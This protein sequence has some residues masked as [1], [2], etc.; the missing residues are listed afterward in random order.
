MI[1]VPFLRVR[2]IPGIM[3]GFNRQYLIYSL[4]LGGIE[5]MIPFYR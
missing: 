5:R 4:Q 3:L 2:Y 1:T